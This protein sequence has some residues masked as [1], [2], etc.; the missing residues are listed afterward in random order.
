MKWIDTANIRSWAARRDCQETLPLLVRKLIRAT[1]SSIKNI[2]FPSGENVLIGGWDGLLE[3][4]EETTYIPLGQSVW[5]FGA[6][7]N[8]KGK[9]DDDYD[10]RKQDTLGI[11]PKNAT[12]IFVTPRLWTN[13][14]QWK[15]EKNKEGFWN[16]VRVY[17]AQDLEEWIETAPSVSAWLAIKHL[18][19]FPGGIQPA[20]DFWEE[21][22]TG[23]KIKFLPDV[24][25]AGRKEEVDNLFLHSKQPAII[26]IKASS[27]E[28]ATA[29]IIAAFKNDDRIS[30]DFFAKALIIDSAEAFREILVSD[31]SLY[32]IVRFDDD[33]IINRA[34][35]KGHV[36][37][38]PLGIDN[39]GH[40][41]NTINLP[42]LDRDEFLE[43]LIN[44]GLKEEDAEKLS[45]RSAR[46]LSVL[47]RR[48]EFNRLIPEWANPENVREIIPALLAGRW[49]DDCEDDVRIIETFAGEPYSDYIAKL[50]KWLYSADAPIVQIGNS[51]RLTSPLDAWTY[52]GKY[53]TQSDLGNMEEMYLA[54]FS[55]IDPTFEIPT[56]ERQHLFV[57]KKATYSRWIREG[58]VQN[59]ILVSVYG[60]KIGIDL[61]SAP[62]IWIDHIISKSLASEDPNLWKSLDHE[63]PLIA[64]ASPSAFLLSIERLLSI[65]N[66]PI[67]QLFK[68]V[69]G[70]FDSHSYHTGLLW[71]L[72]GLAWMPEYLSRVTLILSRLSEMDPGGRLSNRPINSLREIF[73]SWHPQS[74][75][76]LS[77]R[78]DSLKLMVKHQSEIGK[79]VIKSLLPS[80][81]S[82]AHGTH[83]M[84]WRLSDEIFP[85]EFSHDELYKTYSLAI[86]LLLEQF[87]YSE[88]SYNELAKKSFELTPWD[89]E[90]VLDFLENKM[91]QVDHS[92]DLT[93]H[94]LRE[95]VGRH[96][97]AL[98]ADWAIPEPGLERYQKL[99]DHLTP[100]DPL[101][102]VTWI[103]R[104]QFPQFIEGKDREAT[105][106]DRAKIIHDKKGEA[107]KFIYDNYG[108]DFLLDFAANLKLPEISSFSA[109]LSAIV[110]K[111][112]D[113]FKIWEGLKTDG[114]LCS[115]AQYVADSKRRAEGN[116]YIFEVFQ[117]LKDNGYPTTAVINLLLKLFAEGE[118]WDFIESKGQEY[119]DEY[120][121]RVNE[122]YISGNLSDFERA[123]NLMMNYRRNTSA[124]KLVYHKVEEFDSELIIKV[125]ESFIGSEIEQ[126]V[127]MDNYEFQHV[128]EE[129]RKKGIEDRNTLIKLEWFFLPFLD[130]GFNHGN[131]PILHQEMANNPEFFIQVLEMLYKANSDNEKEPELTD[132]E[133]VRREH[134]YQAAYK[135][136]NTWDTIPGVDAENKIDE[137]TIND[138]IDR[139]LDLAQKSDRLEAAY[140]QIG[141][142][143]AKYPEGNTKMDNDK[144]LN[145]P[146]DIICE[147]IEKINSETLNNN[148]HVSTYNKRGSSSR[149]AFDG[150]GREWHIAKYFRTLSHLKA[151]KY[152][153]VASIFES[154]AK[155]FE[156]LAKQEDQRAERDKLDY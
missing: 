51:W 31:K 135:L 96:R 139:A 82:I 117:S 148:F 85:N 95:T 46:N 18:S 132:E 84:R 115:M 100:K 112:E 98:T 145:W 109:A 116:K 156:Q 38:V 19:I 147:I 129:L 97:S 124:L 130:V 127:R 52:A 27:R 42:A 67:H 142:L 43:A 80:G 15:D 126:D 25:L 83:R 4:N 101:N 102:Q 14:E 29:F 94:S 72:E 144:E 55:K 121:K 23:N 88:F 138:W 103:L 68:E 92:S 49:K 155:D 37:F 77:S 7:S 114:I 64:E 141:T 143:L 110:S 47:R 125:L 154:L 44:S 63:L 8:V 6:N 87:D 61:P 35:N 13:K 62:S 74:L 152:P 131:T 12:Y 39:S 57:N 105:H 120:W 32:L 11:D 123:I 136:F 54:I 108:I 106:Q 22:S 16:E 76:N 34:R 10:K 128:F 119:V 40:Y 65:E 45:K 134:K 73:K 59:L 146:P 60:D 17:D 140:K 149:G 1:T 33:N 2:S 133:K 58:L 86:E 107:A 70:W 90:K 5:E 9:A 24:V 91:D 36:V 93:W 104:E 50:K 3:V 118:I 28:E 20:D 21:W 89:R 79:T 69:H 66:G 122:F 78:F 71:S 48:L 26:P 41:E 81:H 150:G 153:K 137:G 30:E 151:G 56:E 53:C 113:L 75:A 99:Y 111:E